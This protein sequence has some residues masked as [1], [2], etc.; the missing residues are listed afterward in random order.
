MNKISGWK[1]MGVIFLLLGLLLPQNA[2]ASGAW[3]SL[4]AMEKLGYILPE[5][6][7]SGEVRMTFLG[8]CTLGDEA[9]KR[10]ASLG[11]AK[12]IEK[13]GCEH[14]FRQ[15]RR[16]TSPDDLT[17]ANLE[18]V[19]SDRKLKKVRKEYNFIGS[20]SYTEILTAGSIDCVTLANNHT[21][22]FGEEGY[23]DTKTALNEAG[24][25]WFGTD[26]PAVWISE[27]GFMIGFLGVSYS[28]VG[29]GYKRYR[30]QY[31]SLRDLGCA[32]VVTVM[33]AGTEYAYAAPDRYQKQIVTRAVQCGTDL[34]VGHH[35]HVVQGYTVQEGVPVVYSLGNC[36]FGGTTRARD[37]DALALQVI[38]R[39]E[40]GRLKEQELHFYPISI[41]GDERYNDYSPVFL[42]G[43]GA[44]RVLAK[45]EKS[46]GWAPGAFGEKEG[47]VVSISSADAAPGSE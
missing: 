42:T 43:T 44:E 5:E 45:M 31:Q 9:R 47:A 3:F 33:H 46:T 19:L 27:E 30:E 37:S 13:M 6:E 20:A 38:M 36:S 35:P 23:E 40:K 18:T 7:R 22:D 4:S 28:L 12:T 17:V 8:D 29:N 26:S 39:F 10:N 32:A 34:V 2:G 16:L 25:A 15:L 41:T 24:V 1:R 21:H 11:F 14:P